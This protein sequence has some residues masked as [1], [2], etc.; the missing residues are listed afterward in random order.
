MQNQRGSIH[1]II[2]GLL[3][4][5]FIGTVGFIFWQNFMVA[6]GSQNVKQTS[7]TKDTKKETT[8]AKKTYC[9]T[10]EKVCFDYPQD[11]TIEQVGEPSGDVKDAFTITDPD[12]VIVLAF[13]SGIGAHDG[14]CCGPT[15]EGPATVLSAV[16]VPDFG[17]VAHGVSN[18]DPTDNV[19]VSEVVTTSVK[20]EYPDP[21]QPIVNSVIKG[22]VPQIVLHNASDLSTPQTVT[23]TMGSILM[24][25][26]I[27]GKYAQAYDDDK[28]DHG[29]FLFGT[30]TFGI[31]SDPKVY[32][33]FDKAKAQLKSP[34]F[35]Q[36]KEIL[37]SARYK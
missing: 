13:Q 34:S 1:A 36:A 22:Y 31:E 29:S 23:R 4:L 21:S 14:F 28:T 25:S 30:V 9:A 8:V 17:E 2:I 19:Y 32:D 24:D 15:P 18:K 7:I 33:S 26:H 12:N 5:G 16:K 11:W 3:T 10:F 37:L 6:D 20:G 27:S 35:Q